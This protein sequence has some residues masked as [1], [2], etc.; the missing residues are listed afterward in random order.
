M[1]Y[2]VKYQ[3]GDVAIWKDGKEPDNVYFHSCPVKRTPGS[4]GFMKVVPKDIITNR[5]GD[6][7]TEIYHDLNDALIQCTLEAL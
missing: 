4:T 2:L 5:N 6:G 3:D 1:Y 7:E